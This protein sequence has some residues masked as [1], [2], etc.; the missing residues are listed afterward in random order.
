VNGTV[1]TSTLTFIVNGI[2]RNR[3][4]YYAT[5]LGETDVSTASA[6]AVNANEINYYD[7]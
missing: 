1:S 7:V 5:S 2:K 6:L 3:I 4:T